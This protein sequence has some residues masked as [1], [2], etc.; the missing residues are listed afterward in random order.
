MSDYQGDDCARCTRLVIGAGGE[1]LRLG[2]VLVDL[3]TGAPTVLCHE[4]IT[5][6][7]VDQVEAQTATLAALA[8]RLFA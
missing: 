7:E 2:R 5:P 3:E 8:R 6:A 1:V 4:C